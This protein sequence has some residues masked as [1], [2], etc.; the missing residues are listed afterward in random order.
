MNVENGEDIEE[1]GDEEDED[2]EDKEDENGPKLN[3]MIP[4]EG[5]RLGSSYCYISLL[6]TPTVVLINIRRTTTKTE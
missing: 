3:T 5:P 4:Q 6:L 1:E 2:G